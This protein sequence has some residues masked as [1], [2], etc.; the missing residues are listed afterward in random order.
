[1]VRCLV[2]N[3]RF[4]PN[5]ALAL[6]PWATRPAQ[7]ARGSGNS[8][9]PAPLFTALGRAGLPSLR[10][11]V[12][13]PGG[14]AHYLRP[15][16]DP[17]PPVCERQCQVR[18]PRPIIYGTWAN[19]AAQFARGSANSGWPCPIIR[20]TWATRGCQF[21]SGRAKSGRPDPLFTA[22]GRAGLP[23]LR[24]AVPPG[25][26]RSRQKPPGAARSRQEPAGARYDPSRL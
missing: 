19:R 26:A 15:L 1:M 8:G 18:V 21:A 2:Y 22:L 11:V 24:E 12:P 20:G 16:G 10:E 6:G 3:R 13:I 7:F 9:W 14:P 23:S 5:F 4:P 17:G 25:A